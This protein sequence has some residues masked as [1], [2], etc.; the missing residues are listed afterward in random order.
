MSYT[1]SQILH[2]FQGI[3]KSFWATYTIDFGTVDFLMKKDF[4]QI[5]NHNYMHVISDCEQFNHSLV[6]EIESK[7]SLLKVK[8]LQE[9]CTFSQQETDGAFHP[10]ILLLAS[11]TKVVVMLG[12]ANLTSSGILSNQDLMTVLVYEKGST[13]NLS[14]VAAAY[15]YLS[16]MTSW[17][18]EAKEDLMVIGERFPELTS[19]E[20]SRFLS[21]PNDKS[22]LNQ[23]MDK[24]EGFDY[25]RVCIFSPFFDDELKGLSR[26]SEM[27]GKPI[28]AITPNDTLFTNSGSSIQGVEIKTSKGSHRPSFH[29]KFYQFIG[30][31]ESIVFWGS[32]NCSYSG[33]IDKNRNYE[34]LLKENMQHEDVVSLWGSYEAYET[35]K[36][37]KKEPSQESDVS[38]IIKIR[39][40]E[41]SGEKLTFECEGH[42][43]FQ[44]VSSDGQ[45]KY[46]MSFN[47]VGSIIQIEDNSRIMLLWWEN[48][49]SKVMS[50]YCYINRPERI[51]GRLSGASHQDKSINY[52]KQDRRAFKSIFGLFN[53]EQES[54]FNRPSKGASGVGF[55]RMPRYS[56]RRVTIKLI[57][58]REF[59][60]KETS[61]ITDFSD[62]DN[63][64]INNYEIVRNQNED[65]IKFVSSQTSKL[66]QNL[67]A[68]EK[69]SLLGSIYWGEW[70]R[71][72]E[73]L[74]LCLLKDKL[75]VNNINDSNCAKIVRTL[76]LVLLW[77]LH[78][79]EDGAFDDDDTK[80]MIL[81]LTELAYC[82]IATDLKK[83]ERFDPLNQKKI[84]VLHQDFMIV[85]SV[86]KLIEKDISL[87]GIFNDYLRLLTNELVSKYRY[88]ALMSEVLKTSSVAPVEVYKNKKGYI[89]LYLGDKGE[90]M[91]L[92]SLAGEKKTFIKNAPLEKTTIL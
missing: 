90:N 67:N 59:V 26:L 73:L 28:V 33:L 22:L 48:H 31:N 5:M 65:L 49:D 69:G 15:S 62:E 81:I 80:Q 58:F 46:K 11:E 84:G 89:Y 4:R 41:F 88:S 21:I 74:L 16:S 61:K 86:K 30:K 44:L 82:S 19:G 55:W 13:N 27:A 71:G 50:N 14:E 51:S 83:I 53:I 8:Q 54:A 70:K 10:K 38:A 63:E 37:K 39:N 43:D 2:E 42:E 85:T 87:D 25:E 35:V 23:M 66:N 6:K 9:Y 60:D 76:P 34:F 75:L 78:N 20:N 36:I 77:C 3:D 12:S 92:L 57:N 7:N 64:T 24:L 72:I 17:I 40:L 47:T 52:D 45:N 18:V 79:A 91:E 68:I 56:K 1:I 29:S 32:A